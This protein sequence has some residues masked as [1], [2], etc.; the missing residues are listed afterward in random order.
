MISQVVIQ[1]KDRWVLAGAI[2]LAGVMAAAVAQAIYAGWEG[3]VRRDAWTESAEGLVQALRSGADI[4]VID[5][6]STLAYEG[7]HVR[8]ALSLPAASLVDEAFGA[9][10]LWDEMIDAIARAGVD[11]S[12]P[13]V[14]YAADPKDAAYV[15]WALRAAG[16]PDV[17]LL[18][19]GVTALVEAGAPFETG[20]PRAEPRPVEAF[21]NAP[22]PLDA[23][24][25]DLAGLYG[26]SLE[27][28][29]L[30]D[31]RPAAARAIDLAGVAA[32]VI[33]A[34]AL[35]HGDGVKRSRIA[36]KKALRPL[37]D[38]TAIVYGD[39]VREAALVWWSLVSE[40]KPAKL[41]VDG[42]RL[43]EQSGLPT[44]AAD[45]APPLAQPSG[46]RVGGGCG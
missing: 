22:A 5:A 9:T 45:R 34:A 14:V 21:A 23:I 6:R 35:V 30:V 44:A 25:I 15:V 37:G 32:H 20:P 19:G 42:F 16:V 1:G 46:M 8:G 4:Q 24:S 26:R 33:D 39:D 27:P 38:E 43:W 11:P 41:F 10:L 3:I 17:R 36:V 28:I 31:A 7:G 40:G 2:I 29:Q 18:A 12:R 13:A